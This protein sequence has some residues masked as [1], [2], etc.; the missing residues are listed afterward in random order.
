MRAGLRRRHAPTARARRRAG[1]KWL[2]RRRSEGRARRAWQGALPPRAPLGAAGERD[3]R[4]ARVLE[5]AAERLPHEAVELLRERAIRAGELA[6][7][8]KE[9]PPLVAP[10]RMLSS[11]FA[12]E[13]LEVPEVP[14]SRLGARA[15]GNDRGALHDRR[16]RLNLGLPCGLGLPLG[17]RGD[18]T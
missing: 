7:V 11:V 14:A 5:Q 8:Q 13:P 16:R 10:L 17:T 15:E 2:A 9:I 4:P 1:G 6:Q 18:G 12:R 3:S